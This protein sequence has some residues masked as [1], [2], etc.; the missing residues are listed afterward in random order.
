[1]AVVHEAGFAYHE[2]MAFCQGGKVGDDGDSPVYF[3]FQYLQG[4]YGLI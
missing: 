4:S 2:E 1:M 3:E